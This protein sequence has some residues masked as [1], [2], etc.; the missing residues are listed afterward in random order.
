MGVTSRENRGWTKAV[1]PQ[2]RQESTA[3]EGNPPPALFL[4]L[5]QGRCT[6]QARNRKLVRTNFCSAPAWLVLSV[7][8]KVVAQNKYPR[9]ISIHYA[10]SQT[11]AGFTIC[12]SCTCHLIATVTKGSLTRCRGWLLCTA[13]VPRRC[14]TQRRA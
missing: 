5:L 2:E 13:H 1:M 8:K 14:S 12:T 11:W 4:L 3:G 6:G 9:Q 7:T 10:E